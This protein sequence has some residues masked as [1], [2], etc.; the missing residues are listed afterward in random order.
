MDGHSTEVSGL[1][2]AVNLIAVTAPFVGVIVAALLLWGHGFHWQSL[3]IFALMYLLTAGGVTVGFHRLFTHRA[4]ETNAVVKCI[5]AFM[6]SMAIEGPLFRWVATHRR[7][8]QHAD[9]LEDP[10]SPHLHGHGMLGMLRGL[11]HAHM[12]W[13]FEPD[14]PGMARYVGDLRK[15]PM[16]RAMNALFPLW[17]A[18]SM[19]LPAALGGLLSLSWTG[20]L[21]GFL[22]GGLVRL[23]VLHHITWSINSVCHLWGYKSFRAGDESRNN[24]VFGV[25][26]LGEGWHN[27]H[28]AF[29]TSAR[30][31]L[32][33]WELDISYWII[34]AM[35]AVGLAWKVRIPEPAAI[36]AKRRI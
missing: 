21:L 10:H 2:K 15:D 36:A 4:Y 32:R 25:L 9:D 19:L 22:W 13:M 24:V 11:W 23:F 29:P 26:A 5:L 12:G 16:L 31:G 18:V 3:V 30:H 17:A 34:R 7:H 35:Q 8:H 14:A 33:W 1:I 20:A 28:H 27:N 6:G